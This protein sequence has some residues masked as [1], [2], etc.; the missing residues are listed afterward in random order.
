MAATTSI[1][2]TKNCFREVETTALDEK[3]GCRVSSVFLRVMNAAKCKTRFPDTISFSN[4]R[5]WRLSEFYPVAWFNGNKMNKK[6]LPGNKI[7][8]R[9][10]HSIQK[11]KYTNIFLEIEPK[12]TTAPFEKLPL[13]IL[14]NLRRPK[15][16]QKDNIK[17]VYKEIR[18]DG[19]NRISLA[20]NS[21]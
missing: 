18:D 13:L 8:K 10:F 20:Q 9:L 2:A 7:G 15:S 6:F 4:R 17:I 21:F 3:H 16:K 5:L 19:I 12:R 14:M 11:K 1:L